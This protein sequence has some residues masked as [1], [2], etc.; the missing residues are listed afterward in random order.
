L[1]DLLL[2]RSDAAVLV[3]ALVASVV[4]ATALLLA[5]RNRELV[6]L[7]IG[8]PR[9]RAGCSGCGPSTETC[10]DQSSRIGSWRWSVARR[11]R[12][13][14][15]GSGA[16][17]IVAAPPKVVLFDVVETMF[18]LRPVAAASEPLGLRVEAFFA[19]R[20]RCAATAAARARDSSPST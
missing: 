18:S 1:R 2:P 15:G 8:S 4:L 10:A 5:R 16:G 17:A 7:V 14:R 6:L 9:S 3:Q 20:R 13:G 11:T 12:M 19:P